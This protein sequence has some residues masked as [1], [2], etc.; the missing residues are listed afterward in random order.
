MGKRA[1]LNI[2]TAGLEKLIVKLDELDGDVKKA[3]EKALDEAGKEITKDTLSAIDKSNL[4]RQGEYSRG[5]TKQSVVQNPKVKW[6]GST[7]SIAVGFDYDKPGAG[8][9]LITGTPKM[10]PDKP[11]NDMYK[12]KKYASNI[13]KKMSKTVSDAIKAK[14]G[15]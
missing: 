9:L 15:E 3:V 8:G 7:A 13:S 11:L 2:S 6:E 14:M 12:G 4:P 1:T 10:R 5:T